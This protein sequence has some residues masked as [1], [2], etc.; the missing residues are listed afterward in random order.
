MNSKCY[1]KNRRQIQPYI[2]FVW[3]FLKTLSMLEPF[4]N[5][6]VFRGVKSGVASNYPK[7]R[8]FTW[9]GFCSLT[10]SAEVLERVQFCGSSGVRTIFWVKLTQGQ[11]RDIKPYSMYPDEDE[12][13]LPP[14]CSFEVKGKLDAGNGL[15]II[16]VEE[17][18]SRSWI[19]D[20]SRPTVKERS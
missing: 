6:T 5:D 14:G 8:E 19:L 2:K 7:G 16:Q 1:L 11:A 10:R 12:V 18:P 3:L 15:T 9:H 17:L 4:P 20:L 13:L